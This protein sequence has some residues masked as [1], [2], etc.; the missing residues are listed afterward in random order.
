MKNHIQTHKTL[1]GL[2]TALFVAISSAPLSAQ[3]GAPA[4]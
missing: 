2:V 3:V 1:L 4:P